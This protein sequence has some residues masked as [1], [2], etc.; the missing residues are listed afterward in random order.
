M[1]QSPPVHLLILGFYHPPVRFGI[2][3][4]RLWLGDFLHRLL[5]DVQ[6]EKADDPSKKHDTG[7][8][9]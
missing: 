2:S 7:S 6:Q 4:A 8:Y 1:T 3:N 9:C 5:P